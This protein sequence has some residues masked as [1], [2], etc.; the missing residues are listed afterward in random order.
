MSDGCKV[1]F[2]MVEGILSFSAFLLQATFHSHNLHLLTF[3]PFTIGLSPLTL[4][5]RNKISSQSY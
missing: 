5:H 3:I 2:N 1:I 4:R